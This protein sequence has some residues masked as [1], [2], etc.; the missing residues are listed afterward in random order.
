LSAWDKKGKLELQ[1]K[2]CLDEDGVV[3]LFNVGRYT[4]S[5][6]GVEYTKRMTPL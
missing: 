3:E 6:H 4:E 5:R 1:T 2:W